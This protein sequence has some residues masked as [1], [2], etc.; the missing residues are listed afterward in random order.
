ML[1]VLKKI[2]SIQHCD[3]TVSL[4]TSFLRA[5]P[6][7]FGANKS[8]T[9]DVRSECGRVHFYYSATLYSGF[10]G[11][12]KSL[13]LQPSPLT[14]E[15]AAASQNAGLDREL[16]TVRSSHYL[17]PTI[18]LKIVTSS[19]PSAHPEADADN[20]TLDRGSRGPADAATRQ[21]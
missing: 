6:E 9:D 3:T 14:S 7:K 12:S 11:W 5:R 15:S 2:E 4:V 18:G 19:L 16:G 20:L 10:S 17:A 8:R 21:K 13:M 1:E